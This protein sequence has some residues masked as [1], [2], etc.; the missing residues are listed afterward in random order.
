[1][2]SSHLFISRTILDPLHGLWVA[3][4]IARGTRSWLVCVSR[5][6]P[7]AASYS[8]VYLCSASKYL[9]IKHQSSLLAS[10]P[11]CSIFAASSDSCHWSIGVFLVNAVLVVVILGISFYWI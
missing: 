3:V 11:S 8:V 7:A 2:C 4:V 1:M 10:C 6:L 5:F 9:T